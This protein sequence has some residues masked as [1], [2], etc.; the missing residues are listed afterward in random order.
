MQIPIFNIAL[1]NSKGLCKM[2]LVQTP[3]V[4][5]DFMAFKEQEPLKFSV[6]EEQ[7]CLFGCALR[8]DY[9]I[10]R[11]DE[12]YGEYY[13]V[14]SK[15]TIRQLYEKYM[16]DGLNNEVNLEHKMDTNGVYMLQS[17]VKDSEKGINP[18]GFEQVADGSWFVMYKVLNDDVW[19]QVKD[20]QYNG[21]SVEMFGIIEKPKVEEEKDL[22]DEVLGGL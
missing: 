4:D 12:V 18:V 10:Y 9:P 7:R 17:F 15:E 1:G 5:V 8:A 20:G 6:D 14:F 3:A 11:C 2:S 22:I 21:F 19:A 13:V 16:V